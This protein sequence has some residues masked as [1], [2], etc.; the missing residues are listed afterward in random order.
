MHNQKL[1]N[2][3][4][5]NVRQQAVKKLAAYMCL[6][7]LALLLGALTTAQG[8]TEGQS[9]PNNTPK[10][11]NT[12]KNLGPA[13]PSETIDVSIWL[14]PHNREAMD[15]LAEELY[16]PNSSQYHEW[17]TPAAV[18]AKFGPTAE[19]AQTVA[20]FLS[21]H[22]LPVTAIG[23]GNLY[24]RGRGTIASVEAAFQVKIDTFQVNGQVYRA[25]TSNPYLEGAIA[26]LTS[27]VS[28]L[29]NLTYQHPYV[30]RGS[31]S[32]SSGGGVQAANTADASSGFITPNCFT[33][34]TT[35]TYSTS[36]TYPIGTY[37]GNGYNG[38]QNTAGCGYTPAEIQTAYHL[39]GLYNEGFDGT[40]QTVVI[41][42][43]CGSPTIKSDANAF[44]ARFGLPPL[45]SSN[46]KILDSSTPPTCGSPDPEI[47]IDVEWAHAIAPGANID[48][49]VPPSAS[50]MDVDDAELY[51]IANSLGNVISGSYGS[52]EL[53]T[54][55]AVL[56]EENLINEIA[57]MV[58]ISADFATGDSGDFTFDFPQFDPASVSAPADSPYATGVGGVTLA[59]K[60]NN[61]IAWQ[62][63]WGNNETGLVDQG[64]VVDP[65]ENFGFYAG[66]GGGPSAVFSKPSFQKK[67]PG[68]QRLLPDI[69]WLADPF[70]GGIIAISEPGVYPPLEW[71]VYGGTS[72][73]TPMF[74]AL[75][76]IANQEAG[77]PLGQAARHLYTMPAGTITDVL[78]INSA[79]NVTASIEV[80]PGFF[81]T[82]TAAQIAAPLENTTQFYS[83]IWDYPLYQDTVYVVTFGTDSGLTVTPGWDDVTGLGTPNGKAFADYFN[84]GKP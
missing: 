4:G 5:A 2:A 46:F 68:S 66:S 9:I 24:V 27:G 21:S 20:K 79:T 43:W 61:S 72:L 54:S 37:T 70:T 12:A 31:R 53:Y 55:S 13:N 49:V 57:A 30:Q 39:T 76:A 58:G 7:A 84:P 28:G 34:V 80:A 23:P 78:P 83:A 35:Q 36:G 33:G 71:T 65:P 45:T 81:D 18:F 82:Y 42:D 50:F 59:L 26:E 67:L 51:A 69:S 25:N 44:S 75:W 29:D 62:T 8:A 56:N 3:K 77:V 38:T 14:N 6:I 17:L 10:F 73:A 74:S 19:E 47:N 16:D 15:G 64:T 41:I 63:G 52:E 40:G 22:N 11:V 60:S 32:S 1:S 48:L